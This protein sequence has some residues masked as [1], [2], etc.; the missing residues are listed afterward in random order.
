MTAHL[1][2]WQL[3]KQDSCQ[4]KR[5]CHS[6]IVPLTCLL[7]LSPLIK[8]LYMFMQYLLFSFF[9]SIWCKASI[10]LVIIVNNYAYF[11]DLQAD[12]AVV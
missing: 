6:F 4:T 12:I 11:S 9:P 3:P 2:T 8:S 10:Y 1:S 5:H 7:Y